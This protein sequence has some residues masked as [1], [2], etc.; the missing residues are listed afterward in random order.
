MIKGQYSHTLPVPEI[1]TAGITESVFDRQWPSGALLLTWYG[2][3]F[4]CQAGDLN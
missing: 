2:V 1:M 4:L 3:R